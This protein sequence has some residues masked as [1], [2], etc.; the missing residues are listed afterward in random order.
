[1]RICLF[2]GITKDGEKA[3][4][5]TLIY[6]ESPKAPEILVPSMLQKE[7]E[8]KYPY[9][10]MLA[11]VNSGGETY[12]EAAYPGYQSSF[13][14]DTI[15][16]FTLAGDLIKLEDQTEYM[17]KRLGTKR[18]PVT[19]EEPFKGY[20][21]LPFVIMENGLSTA[22]NAC[23]TTA[24]VLR[25]IAIL[26][27]HGND[28]L[29]KAYA[30]H[31][32]PGMIS[33]ITN[34]VNENGLFIEDPIFSGD[35]NPDGRERRFGLKV[36]Y[37]KD[38]ELNREGRREPHYPIVYMLAHFQNAE[39]LQR[40]GV[41]LGDERTT[42]YGRYMKEA[43]LRFLKKDDHFVTAIDQD[44]V[45]DAPSSDSLTALLYLSS[46]EL[47]AGFAQKVEAYMRQLETPVGY[48]SGIPAVPNVDPYHMN[49]WTHEQALMNAAAGRHGLKR[50]EYITRGI[51]PYL[52]P[53]DELFPELV[54]PATLDFG[55]G[56]TLQLWSIGAYYHMLNPGDSLFGSGNYE[57]SAKRRKQQNRSLAF[58]PL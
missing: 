24:E 26:A 45:V 5:E 3:M 14:R 41:V 18:D 1:M 58:E 39:A 19:G 44:G 28:R 29:L 36:T 56:N 16:A 57:L 12:Y 38:S 21:Q 8:Q 13:I 33:Y 30:A 7:T 55:T 11:V 40:I 20:H 10:D 35:T 34:H 50:A 9:F 37:W 48:R 47:P 6:P 53:E 32:I 27:E 43:G 22:Y 52:I 4:G 25:A 23:D 17:V 46:S 42:R 31:E 15:E 49:V 54:D 2:S 51:T